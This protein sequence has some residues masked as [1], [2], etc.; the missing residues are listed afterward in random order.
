[1]GRICTAGEVA[2]AV[3]WLCTRATFSTGQHL[4]LDGGS[5]AG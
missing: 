4:A 2:E 5:L 1:M 3:L